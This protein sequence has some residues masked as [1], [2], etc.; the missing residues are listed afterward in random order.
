MHSSRCIA[1]GSDSVGVGVAQVEPSSLLMPQSGLQLLAGN[2]YD[3]DVI[4]GGCNA[5][6]LQ[7]HRVPVAHESE[8]YC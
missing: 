1:L 6:S 3:R 7:S 8:N 2:P 5:T 4:T